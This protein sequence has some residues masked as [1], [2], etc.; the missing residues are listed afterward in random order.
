MRNDI[1]KSTLIGFDF[2]MN[3]P[4]MTAY[5]N[6]KLYFY[7]WP[8]KL[9]DKKEEKYKDCCVNVFPRGLDAIDPK[10]MDNSQIVLIHTIR[11]SE[12]S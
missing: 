8:L 3:K 12:L 5:H 11:A 4:A 9:S 10:K 2:S 6:G 7:F 1:P